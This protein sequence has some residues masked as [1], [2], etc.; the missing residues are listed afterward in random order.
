KRAETQ[1]RQKIGERDEAEPGAGMGQG[2]GQPADRDALQPPAD[3]RDAVAGGVDA[4]VALGEDA[5]DVVEAAV[6]APQPVKQ[7]GNAHPD[8]PLKQPAIVEQIPLVSTGAVVPSAW[9]GSWRAAL[10]PSRRRYAPP[11]DDVLS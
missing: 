10:R 5:G 11:Q 2:P 3:Q 9:F 4:V 1:H 7:Q 8:Q 6:R